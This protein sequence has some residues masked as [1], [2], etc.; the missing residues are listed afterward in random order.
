MPYLRKQQ[1]TI[2]N[3]VHAQISAIFFFSSPSFANSVSKKNVIQFWDI[4][5]IKNLALSRLQ[6]AK[7]NKE[8]K[9]IGYIC[10]MFRK[11]KN[12][13]N[14]SRKVYTRILTKYIHTLSP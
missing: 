2:T 5:I 3:H 1:I 14:S 12:P 13:P 9:V 10:H 8:S 7:Q 11:F 4:P 6:L